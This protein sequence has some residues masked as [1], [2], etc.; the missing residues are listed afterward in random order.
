MP[1]IRHK[2]VIQTPANKVYEVITTEHGLRGWW[3]PDTSFNRDKNEFRFGF[4]PN[5]FKIMKVISQTSGRVEWLCTEAVE[6]WVGTKLIFGITPENERTVLYFSHEN[7]KSY[8]DMFSQCCYDWAMFLRSL[9]LLCEKGKGL[10]FPDQH[11]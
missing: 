1:H 2:L 3:T 5:Y 8:T 6:E 10:P 7:W 9:R 11:L 4:G